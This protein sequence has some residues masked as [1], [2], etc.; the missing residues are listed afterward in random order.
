MTDFR[1]NS[2]RRSNS[3]GSDA[4]SIPDTIKHTILQ[5]GY[6]VV[7]LIIQVWMLMDTTHKFSMN[8]FLSFFLFCSLI[9]D[10]I[11]FFRRY[12]LMDHFI[13]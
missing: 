11:A 3:K 4:T 1:E 12:Q 5:L 10:F 9:F 6:T 13:I 7:I 8:W 2:I